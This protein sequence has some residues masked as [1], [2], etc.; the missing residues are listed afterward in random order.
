MIGIKDLFRF[1]CSAAWEWFFV[2]SVLSLGYFSSMLVSAVRREMQ[3]FRT[4][5]VSC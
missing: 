2:F 5:N 1:G 4:M 3:S